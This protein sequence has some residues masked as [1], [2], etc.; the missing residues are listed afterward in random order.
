MAETGGDD[1]ILSAAWFAV[2]NLAKLFYFHF[3]LDFIFRLAVVTRFPCIWTY[4]SIVAGLYYM[5]V[6]LLYLYV[7]C[8]KRNISIELACVNIF[9]RGLGVPKTDDFDIKTGKIGKIL[10]KF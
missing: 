1:V 10:A 4:Y 3:F 9:I 2:I 5:C 6:Y 8:I 7:W